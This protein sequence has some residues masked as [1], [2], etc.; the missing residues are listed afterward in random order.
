MKSLP[1]FPCPHRSICCSWGSSL[2]DE[3]A[4]HIR[5]NHGEAAVVR[6]EDEWRTAVVD[7][8]CVFRAEHGC[9][10]HDAAYYPAICR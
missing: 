5:D 4:R 7:G 3:E 9:G 10:I 1:C 2:T 6:G 8:R